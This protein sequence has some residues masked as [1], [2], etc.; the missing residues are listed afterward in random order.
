MSTSDVVEPRKVGDV[1]LDDDE[2]RAR[3]SGLRE[4]ADFLAAHPEIPVHDYDLNIQL[5]GFDKDA[6]VAVVRA[7]GA[8]WRKLHFGSIFELRTTFT[9]DVTLGLNADRAEVCERVV[10]G[11]KTVHH[12]AQPAV[13]EH[14]EEVE[15]VE[16]V[17]HPLLGD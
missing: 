10:T 4:L 13:E 2:R 1:N 17:C 12:D 15:T 9:G 14:D 16:W 5:Y 3:I 7:G 11:T 6:L 8:K